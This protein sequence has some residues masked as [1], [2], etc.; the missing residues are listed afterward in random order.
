[1]A[2]EIKLISCRY[3]GE[4]N[5]TLPL[6]TTATVPLL[7]EFLGAVADSYGATIVM[8]GDWSLPGAISRKYTWR[9]VDAN[10]A[11]TITPP[12]AV[13]VGIVGDGSYGW[14]GVGFEVAP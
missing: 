4:S 2:T 1:M 5:P 11:G 6:D 3:D 7:R 12:S 14:A 13:V 10:G 8:R 9:G